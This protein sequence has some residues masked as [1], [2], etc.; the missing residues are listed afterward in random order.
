MDIPTD[1]EEQETD[2]YKCEDSSNVFIG[3]AAEGDFVR[4]KETFIRREHKKLSQ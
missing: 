4:P 1:I 3:T 2:Y